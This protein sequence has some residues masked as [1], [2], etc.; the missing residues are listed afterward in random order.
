MIV[1]P[2]ALRVLADP[3]AELRP[4]VEVKEAGDQAG[5]DAYRRLR[6]RA[7]IDDRALFSRDDLDEVD[8]DSRT[9]VLVARHH[10]GAVVGGVRLRPVTADQALGWWAVSRLAV[11][12]AARRGGQ[13][14]AAK[15]L[16]AACARAEAGGALHL[17]ATVARDEERFYASLGWRRIRPTTVAGLP[18]LAMGWPLP[19][20]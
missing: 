6:R 10:S 18:H 20:R 9:V 4:D 14:V 13:W 2:D 15:L 5:L 11:D 7:C 17:E 3:A 8:V 19:S 16:R 12:C 1:L